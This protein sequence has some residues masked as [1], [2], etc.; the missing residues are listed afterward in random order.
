LASVDDGKSTLIGRLLYEA[1]MILED[2]LAALEADSR[3]IGAQAD[4]LD[5]VLLVDGLSAECEYGIT[6]D[7][8]ARSRLPGSSCD[9]CWRCLRRERQVGACGNTRQP[10]SLLVC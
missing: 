5:F 6:I 7:A 9:T 10:I 1:K 3:R 2:Q 8:T 4:E